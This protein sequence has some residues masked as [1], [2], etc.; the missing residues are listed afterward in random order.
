MTSAT[1][2][3]YTTK[4]QFPDQHI[5]KWLIGLCSDYRYDEDCR[6]LANK[7]GVPYADILQLPG[8]IRHIVERVA[9]IL[10]FIVFLVEKHKTDVIFLVAHAEC[11]WYGSEVGKVFTSIEEEQAYYI[12]QLR[13]ASNVLNE[14]VPQVEVRL[15]YARLSG[16]RNSVDY[17]EVN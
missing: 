10:K 4:F 12:D 1:R 5:C 16:D 3:L 9:I 7:E 13:E 14:I 11:G 2:V 8:F 6:E 17:L 15:R